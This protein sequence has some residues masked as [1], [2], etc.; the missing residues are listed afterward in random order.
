MLHSCCVKLYFWY[1]ILHIEKSW[2]CLFR[3]NSPANVLDWGVLILISFSAVHELPLLSIPP[4]LWYELCEI[5]Y[6]NGAFS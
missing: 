5:I 6:H 2:L 4:L 1:F 3:L